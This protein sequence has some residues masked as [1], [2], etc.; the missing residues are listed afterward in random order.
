M[1]VALKEGVKK[2]LTQVLSTV[3]SP[4]WGETGPSYTTVY[5]NVPCR[6]VEESE[7]IRGDQ[8]QEI[9][10]SAYLYVSANYDIQVGQQVEIGGKTHRVV[11]VSTNR[12]ETGT[13]VFLKVWVV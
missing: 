9:L 6:F 8:E 12:D 5:T 11:K 2:F 3:K 1:S 10:T 7:W 4:T 13:A